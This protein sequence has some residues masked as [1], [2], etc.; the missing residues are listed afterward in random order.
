MKSLVLVGV[1]LLV[2]GVLSFIVPI[3]QRE[4]HSVR[5]GD[6]KIGVRTENS[7]KLPTP[8]GIVLVAAGVAVLVLG[9]RK[10]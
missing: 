1:L 6:A 8:V 2:L 4:E 7:Q 3:P 10:S 9:T 5:I